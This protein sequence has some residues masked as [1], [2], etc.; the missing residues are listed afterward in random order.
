MAVRSVRNNNPGNIRTNSTAW[1]G[2]T[3][4]DGAFV[5]FATPEHGVRA[6]GRTLETYQDKHGLNTVEGM[7]QRW[8]PPNE[9]DTSGYVD[10]V[11]N[12]MGIDK[13]APIDLDKNPEL[14]EKMVAAMIQK[15]GGQE[16]LDYFGDSIEGGLGMAYGT[17][18]DGVPVIDDDDQRDLISNGE[19]IQEPEA[20]GVEEIDDKKRNAIRSSGSL[21]ELLQ[22]MEQQKLFWENELDAF[23]HYTYNLDLFIVN[24]QEANKFLAYEQ[25]PQMMD[26]IVNDAWPTNDMKTVT[27]ARTGITT[28]LNITDLTI[29]S[30]GAGTGSASKMA[31]TATNLQFTISQVG[32]TSLPDMLQNSILIC[33]YPD[34]QNATFFMK[35]RFKGYDETGNVVKNLPATKIFPFVITKY[36]ELQSVTESKGTN[37]VIDGTIVND[38]VVADTELSQM[39][40]NFEFDVANTLQETLENFFKKLNEKIVERSIVSDSEFI[41]DYKFEMDDTFKQMF[42]QGQMIDPEQANK[43]SG[44]NEVDKTTSVKVGKQTGVITPGSSIYNAIESICL[45]SKEIRESLTEDEPKM[46][47]LFRILPHARPKLGGYNVLT[48]KQTYE[49]TYFLTV[50]RSLIVQNQL[51]N[52][53]L[54]EATAN[55]LKSVF[56]EGH[57]NKRY[58]YQYTGANEHILDLNISL[59]NQLQKAYVLPSDAYMA[60]SFLETVGDWRN[61][62]DERAQQKLTELEQEAIGLNDAKKMLN[63]AA[64]QYQKRFDDIND[65]IRNEFKN[66]I[67]KRITGPDNADDVLDIMNS[68]NDMDAQQMLAQFD[69]DSEEYEILSE[70]FKGEVRENYNKLHNQ[71]Q[72][73]RTGLN[74]V[75]VDEKENEVQTNNL[76]REALG[77]LYST[78][79]IESTNMIGDNWNE[80]GLFPG[81]E[82]QELIL[83]EDL[84][85]EMIKKLSKDQF[86]SLLKALVENPVN[87]S[88]ITK[89][90]L[91]N[92]T[93]LNVIKAADQENVEVAMAKYY[94]GRNNNLSM[95]NAQMTI[96]GDPYWVDSILSPSMEKAKY[97]TKNSL[98]SY[99]MHLSKINGVNYLILVT[100]KAE[101][102]FLND[103]DRV[104]LD[105]ENY[106]GIKK[107]RLMTSVYSVQSVISSFS[108][109]LFTQTLGLVKLPA[110]EEFTEISPIL[111]APEPEL[112]DGD[113]FQYFIKDELGTN[114]GTGRGADGDGKDGAEQ[115]AEA[116]DIKAPVGAGNALVD[117]DG[118]GEGDTVVVQNEDAAYLAASAAYKNA[119]SIFIDNNGVDGIPEEADA[120]QLALVTSQLQDLCNRG[121]Q[122]ACSD[123]AMGRRQIANHFG[124][125]DE[126]RNIINDSI[127]DG[128]TVS[129][130]TIAMLDNTYEAM[131][132]EKISDGV[133]GVDQNEIDEWSAKINQDMDR[134]YLGNNDA[135]VNPNEVMSE[136]EPGGLFG[137]AGS[138]AML[139][140]DVNL[141]DGQIIHNQSSI[142]TGGNYRSYNMDTGSKQNLTNQEF[143]KVQSLHAENEDI[144][145]GRSL[146]DLTDEEYA[147]VKKNEKAIDKITENAQTGIRGQVR[148]EVIDKEKRENISELKAQEQELEDDLDG[149]YW[150][151]KG[152]QEDEEKLKEVR[153]Q[154]LIEQTDSSPVVMTEVQEITGDQGGSH[155]VTDVD[156]KT[157]ED[158][159]VIIPKPDVLPDVYVDNGDGTIT[160]PPPPPN[161]YSVTDDA[162]DEIDNLNVSEE[163]K[164]DLVEALESNNGLK[165]KQVIDGLPT[166]QQNEILELQQTQELVELP[167]SKPAQI[168][169]GASEGVAINETDKKEL[170]AA[171]SIYD[172]LANQQKDLPV[173]VVTEELGGEMVEF[174]YPDTSKFEPVK[175][176]DKNGQVQEY[177]V[178]DHIQEKVN[179]T[180]GWTVGTVNAI[181]DDIANNFDS[182]STGGSDTGLQRSV[183]DPGITRIT[184]NGKPKHFGIEVFVD[185]NIS[186]GEF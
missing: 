30:V 131:G 73:T 43:A 83:T 77:H 112:I 103:P 116:E 174:R 111:D 164:Q 32:G 169:G 56:L 80:L 97:G 108:G 61:E 96:K 85:K 11:A 91:E 10:F 150:T 47:S 122:A 139:N 38:K 72:K 155:F 67:S 88:R 149:W 76:M 159:P 184:V 107:S 23:E 62:I 99:K 100:D 4:D 102:V 29:T 19:V 65:S 114:D 3:G 58:Y 136:L 51:H 44:N 167:G 81:S 60:N 143:N 45:N 17:Q 18:P 121:N 1:K 87:F 89:S 8:A 146:H 59:S 86:S 22:N 137:K 57:C 142:V 63:V 140:G 161:T 90:L 39:D 82:G 48:S 141:Y 128:T 95:L 20:Q 183:D 138:D 55:I 148:D 13:N 64:E 158:D 78:K 168:D 24:Q 163:T 175:Y 129:P 109:G 25:S 70:L 177:I 26:D 178:P 79:I 153:Q 50:Q 14:A 66:R 181:K 110:A 27:I 46:S 101:D 144:I 2:K 71:I 147:Q 105:S 130:A 180:G 74:E 126:A 160:I 36:N 162:I 31:G 115:A 173:T 68:V 98:D 93:N 186:E 94:E 6:L 118:D 69:E 104:G 21:A 119:T 106:D 154:I 42:A 40:Y 156:I 37:I 33:G 15:E 52:A 165:V 28:E 117:T 75:F 170:D 185:E 49:V 123:L 157:T 53:K 7:I 145:A 35:V 132:Q 92:P 134:S 54:T 84:D 113:V 176:V 171:R 133:I 135:V 16:A 5:S 152:R 9:N 151:N 34:L 12:K 125:A 127:D 120:K 41:N 124:E 179:S 182:I 172:N 166:E